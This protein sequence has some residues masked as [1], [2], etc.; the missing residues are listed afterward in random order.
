MGSFC[1]PFVEFFDIGQDTALDLDNNPNVIK[2]EL[3]DRVIFLTADMQIKKDLEGN[4]LQSYIKTT[5]GRIL[6]HQCFDYEE[7]TINI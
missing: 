6:L 4:V 3:D 2:K 7:S 1:S 5:P